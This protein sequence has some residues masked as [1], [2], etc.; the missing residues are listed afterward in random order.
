MIWKN[1]TTKN[2]VNFSYWYGQLHKVSLYHLTNFYACNFNAHHYRS[3]LSFVHHVKRNVNWFFVT[4]QKKSN[5]SVVSL[6]YVMNDMSLSLNATLKNSRKL[7]ASERPRGQCIRIRGG[8]H[9]TQLSKSRP[10]NITG[11]FTTLVIIQI[12]VS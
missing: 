1:D 3:V 5:V 4:L 8:V 6:F 11:T 12:N 10:Y 7:M 2:L 9:F